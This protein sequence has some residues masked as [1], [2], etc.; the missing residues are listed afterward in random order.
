[1]KILTSF[2]MALAFIA[3]AT[4]AAVGQGDAT[5]VRLTF[6]RGW[7]ALPAI[8]GLERGFFAQEGLI[9]SGM[10]VSNSVAAVE[11]LV[12]GTSDFAMLPQRTLL[13]MAASKLDFTVV[14][15]NGWGAEMELVVPKGDAR[16]RDLAGLKGK[17]IALTPGSEA[18]PVLLRLLNR[19]GMRA[20][21]LRIVELG[22]DRLANAFKNGSADA[23]IELRQ[24][25][26]AIVRSGEGRVA[27][28][29]QDITKSI[30][31][32]G[33]MPLIVNNT[34]LEEE[35]ET[36]QKFLNAW[37]KALAYIRQDPEDAAILL[38]IFFHRQG[39]K[40]AD[41]L[42]ESWIRMIRYDRYTWSKSDIADAEYN[43]W[44]LKEGKV[45]KAQPKLDGYFRNDLAERAAKKL[46]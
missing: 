17:R 13:V 35:T 11:S 26:S 41:N 9:V 15:M 43:G 19:A 18:L 40:V 39:V 14:S 21:D 3:A 12:A 6:S 22:A 37:V 1:M 27:I 2:L 42:A 46:F 24:L 29:N 10:P 4:Q 5:L 7:D 8:V 30:G 36:V 45:L 32:I 34:L 25:T 31:R 38:R 33:A 23:I 16:T 28:S 20:A 44:G